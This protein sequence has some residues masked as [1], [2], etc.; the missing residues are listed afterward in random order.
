MDLIK[1]KTVTVLL[2]LIKVEIKQNLGTAFRQT[3]LNHKLKKSIN[4]ELPKKDFM[5]KV[6]IR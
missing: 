2:K 3:Y 1:K 6:E 5:V 4:V